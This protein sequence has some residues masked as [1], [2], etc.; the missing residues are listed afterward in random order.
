MTKKTITAV[1]GESIDVA[2]Y[3]LDLNRISAMPVVDK[4]NQV[5]GI[6]T[7]DDI[8]KLLARRC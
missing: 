4:N 1:P 2:A 8:S 7:S 6:I 5:V 3:R